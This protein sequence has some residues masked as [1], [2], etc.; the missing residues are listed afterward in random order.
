[1]KKTIKWI[2]IVFA[3]FL[4]AH[5]IIDYIFQGIN[6]K[7]TIQTKYHS[8]NKN[9]LIETNHFKI[10]TP[11]NW[12]HVFQGYGYEGNASGCFITRQGIID[13]DYG[14]FSNSYEVD[15]ILVFQQDSMT[16]N[17]FTIYI[18][19]NENNE[20]GI[21]IPRQ[22]EMEFSFDFLMSKVCKENFEELTIG[23]KNLEFKKFYNIEW[24]EE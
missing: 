19:K 9:Q 6:Y 21:H 12:I 8:A 7:E 10:L 4:I 3:F 24:T 1:M 18:G 13:Y 5:F 20:I 15:S 16:L 22:H 2:I 17:R 23:I 14:F 11:K